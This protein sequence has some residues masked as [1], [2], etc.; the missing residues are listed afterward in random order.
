MN[1][2]ALEQP[3]SDMSISAYFDDCIWLPLYFKKALIRLIQTKSL[4][5]FL[6]ISSLSSEKR[7]LL[8][9][10]ISL[11][12]VHAKKIEAIFHPDIL[13]LKPQ[14]KSGV[15]TV[16][17][18]RSIIEELGLKPFQGNGRAILFEDGERFSVPAANALLKVLEEPPQDTLFLMTVSRPEKVLP[19]ILSRA[20]VIRI[21]SSDFS[22]AVME[23][24]SFSF[25]REKM[26]E[27]SYPLFTSSLSRPSYGE[28]IRWASEVS[29]LYEKAVEEEKS[30]ASYLNMQD[31]EEKEAVSSIISYSVGEA[32]FCNLRHKWQKGLLE[33]GSELSGSRGEKRFPDDSLLFFHEAFRQ[34]ALSLNFEEIMLCLVLS[35]FGYTTKEDTS[36][37]DV[38]L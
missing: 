16:E 18:V 37:T 33:R 21:P 28:L 6:I 2:D 1:G 10:R 25:I 29:S 11:A 32:I 9:H 4:H 3:S 36:A 19:T 23:L 14:G 22:D 13:S 35:L 30:V 38:A 12:W 26:D 15:Y 17:N 31:S 27:I 20:E 24:R 8:L 5:H 34:L 7:N